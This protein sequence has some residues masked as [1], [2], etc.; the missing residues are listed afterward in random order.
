[1]VGRISSNVSV[2]QRRG[3][4]VKVKDLSKNEI[5]KQGD[6]FRDG[7]NGKWNKITNVDYFGNK[8]IWAPKC[9]KYGR[10]VS[11][12]KTRPKKHLTRASISTLRRLPPCCNPLWCTCK[13]RVGSGRH[14]NCSRGRAN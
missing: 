10:H 7:N 3:A 2:F 14:I 6:L 12:I 13:Y 11:E 9:F 4:G 8:V 1:M 5:F